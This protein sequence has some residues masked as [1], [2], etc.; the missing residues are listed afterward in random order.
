MFDS[1]RFQGIS[2]FRSIAARAF[3]PF[4]LRIVSLSTLLA[5]LAVIASASTSLRLRLVVR[6]NSALDLGL[7]ALGALGCLV[8]LLDVL[9]LSLNKL[10]R[11]SSAI[12]VPDFRHTKTARM[13]HLFPLLLLF[14]FGLLGLLFLVPQLDVT[15]TALLGNQV[16]SRDGTSDRSLL[17]ARDLGVLLLSELVDSLLLLIG[18]LEVG[19][20]GEHGNASARSM[21]KVRGTGQG[22]DDAESYDDGQVEPVS[23]I[24]VRG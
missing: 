16:D 21:S 7:E 19:L 13:T 23:G 9:L 2:I 20:G 5:S 17:L 3:L 4:S 12:P 15:F 1:D 8:D 6:I 22:C 14:P 24:P 10:R 18:S 11:G